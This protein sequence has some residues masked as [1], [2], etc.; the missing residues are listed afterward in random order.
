MAYKT[1]WK[2]TSEKLQLNKRTEGKMYANM[3]VLES[4]MNIKTRILLC[5]ALFVTEKLLGGLLMQME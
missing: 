4:A 3:T 5:L 2:G 1:P